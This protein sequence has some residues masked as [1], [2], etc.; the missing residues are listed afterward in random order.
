MDKAPVAWGP[1][2]VLENISS[3][4]GLYSKVTEHEQALVHTSRME[5]SRMLTADNL[6]PALKALGFSIDKPRYTPRQVHTN[7]KDLL[8]LPEENTASVWNTEPEGVLSN[9][10]LVLRQV[11]AVLKDCPKPS[12]PLFPKED[13]VVTKMAQLPPSPCRLCGSSKH[14]NRECP[15]YVIY[16]SAYKRNAKMSETAPAMGDEMMYDNTYT[17]LLNQTVSKAAEDFERMDLG[18]HF[19]PAS[20]LTSD[21][22]CKTARMT[23]SI[24]SAE[25]TQEIRLA[26]GIQ[27]SDI[28]DS[29]G[30]ACPLTTRTHRAS[31]EEVPDKDGE[32]PPRSTPASPAVLMEEAETGV[33]GIPEEVLDPDTASPLDWQLRRRAREMR[34]QNQKAAAFWLNDGQRIS[35]RRNQMMGLTRNQDTNTHS[36]KDFWDWKRRKLEVDKDWR[37]LDQLYHHVVVEQPSEQLT[38]M[39]FVRYHPKP[40]ATV[41]GPDGC[42]ADEDLQEP[43]LVELRERFKGCCA[44]LLGQVFDPITGVER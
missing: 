36:V 31:V 23:D 12:P 21:E 33:N 37:V 41:L 13:S 8:D 30:W 27:D 26:L 29:I 24:E 9:D 42:F 44:P 7:M 20:L 5:S 35:T 10:D 19:E 25:E 39:I 14:W 3:T 22:E 1:I 18:S 2:L 38:I 43:D 34:S 16:D 4:M 6:G 17:I 32:D 40:L 28:S 15:H 11:Y